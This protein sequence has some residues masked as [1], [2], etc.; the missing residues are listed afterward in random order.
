VPVLV[1]Q[2][3]VA[4]ETWR[5][6]GGRGSVEPQGRKLMVEQTADVHHQVLVFC[7]KLRRARGVPLRGHFG[8]DDFALTTRLDRAAETLAQP[9]T[10]GFHEPTPLMEIL[11]YLGQETGTFLLIDRLELSRA[12]LSDQAKTTLTA[13]DQPLAEALGEAL[14]PLGLSFRIV[15]R[16]TLQITTQKA[17]EARLQIEFYPI[18]EKLSA[19]ASA[20]AVIEQVKDRVAGTTWSDAGGPGVVHFDEPSGHLIVLQSQPVQAALRRFLAEKP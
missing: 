17:V 11:A 5:S 20:E 4:P 2:R 9:V 7:Q 1:V 10:A 3:L 18:S 15:D 19:G 14:G 16:R 8:P 12:G 6:S 13:E